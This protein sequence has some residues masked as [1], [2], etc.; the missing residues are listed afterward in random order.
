VK[1]LVP[2]A[3]L[4]AALVIPS[5]ASA[6]GCP[7]DG[8]VAYNLHAIRASCYRAT[9]VAESWYERRKRCEPFSDQGGPGRRAC[10]VGAFRCTGSFDSR[11]DDDLVKCAARGG[12]RVY[13]R[14]AH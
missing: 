12:I 4:L 9:N 3:P 14:H 5:A 7:N 13:F 1:R 11:G 6:H 2:L 8:Y 10:R